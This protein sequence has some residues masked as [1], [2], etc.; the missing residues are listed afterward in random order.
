MKIYKTRM[1]STR[2]RTARLIGHLFGGCLH[3]CVCVCLGGVCLGYV[4]RVCVSG[5]G[6]MSQG[7]CPGRSL[8]RLV[9]AQRGC[10]PLDRGGGQEESA[11]VV[12]L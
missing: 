5:K 2:M 11:S 4:S 8:P 3:M 6:Y 7:V 12:C 10:L 9:S 1:H